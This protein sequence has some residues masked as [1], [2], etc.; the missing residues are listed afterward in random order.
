MLFLKL[1]NK[2]LIL[3]YVSIIHKGSSFFWVSDAFGLRKNSEVE[4][5]RSKYF[6][7]ALFGILKNK[8][9]KIFQRSFLLIPRTIV[10]ILSGI[11][12]FYSN[13]KNIRLVNVHKYLLR[14]YHKTIVPLRIKTNLNFA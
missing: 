2:I 10:I 13:L 8:R 3:I 14:M 9:N 11:Y 6:I 7:K 12:N 5:V 1:N 4:K